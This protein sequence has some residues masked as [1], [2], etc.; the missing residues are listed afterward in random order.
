MQSGGQEV[1]RELRRRSVCVYL[2]VCV[3]V[4]RSTRISTVHMK[5]CEDIMNMR[6]VWMNSYIHEYMCE[7]ICASYMST[8]VNKGVTLKKSVKVKMHN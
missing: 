4:H 8:Y 7:F 1:D 5:M 6:C 3:T 2:F